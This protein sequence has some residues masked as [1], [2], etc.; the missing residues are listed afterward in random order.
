[1]QK[2]GH[3]PLWDCSPMPWNPCNVRPRLVEL[4]ANVQQDGERKSWALNLFKLS[5]AKANLRNAVRGDLSTPWHQ[6]PLRKAKTVQFSVSRLPDEIM[7]FP[8][9]LLRFPEVFIGPRLTSALK[10]SEQC[11]HSWTLLQNP[12]LGG[13]GEFSSLLHVRQH[14]TTQNASAAIQKVPVEL[15]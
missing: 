2:K 14:G 5:L 1:M 6:M 8:S 4:A 13:S 15:P 7:N 9:T 3:V 11:K 10:T 12:S